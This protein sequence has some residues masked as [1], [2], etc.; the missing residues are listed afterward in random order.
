MK[1]QGAR[2]FVGRE[3]WARGGLLG[4]EA[5]KMA[6]A[7]ARGRRER[8][9]LGAVVRALVVAVS[10][11]ACLCGVFASGDAVEALSLSGF[12]SARKSAVGVTSPV[13]GSGSA[14]EVSKALG[15]VIP[16]LVLWEGSSSIGALGGALEQMGVLLGKVGAEEK[17]AGASAVAKARADLKGVDLRAVGAREAASLARGLLAAGAQLD[18]AKAGVPEEKLREL[19]GVLVRASRGAAASPEFAGHVLSGLDALVA[20]GYNQAISTVSVGAGGALEVAVTDLTGKPLRGLGVKVSAAKRL[21]GSGALGESDLSLS[22]V[23]GA[24]GVY[25][26]SVSSE[27]GQVAAVK[28]ALSELPEGIRA[29]PSEVGTVVIPASGGQNAAPVLEAATLTLSDRKSVVGEETATF[30]GTTAAALDAQAGNLV[31]V[32]VKGKRLT[33]LQHAAF[34]FE[35]V[36]SKKQLG[37]TAKPSSDTGLSVSISLDSTEF[38]SGTWNVRLVAGNTFAGKGAS[39]SWDLG[40]V[41]L[42]YLDVSTTAAVTSAAHVMPEIRW[43][44]EVPGSR[45]P[46]AVSLLFTALAVMPLAVVLPALLFG[47]VGGVRFFPSG[48]LAPVRLYAFVFHSSLVAAMVVLGAYWVSVDL[49]TTL[50]ILGCIAP[51]SALS[52]YYL[53]SGLAGIREKSE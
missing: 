43:T 1:A 28:V 51:I 18:G 25:A 42:T 6:S 12:A 37:F 32:E 16:A 10:L 2:T 44:F 33:A 23:P 11:C 3:R 49:M 9:E 48:D 40:S 27:K 45:P 21:M 7:R 35:H 53:L 24:E 52:G 19:A 26:A 14:S 39:L 36:Q 46:A 34:V 38:K 15:E 17:K 31:V 50:S 8:R 22:E 4:G 29:G 30:P 5:G 41:S 13:V 47:A 20:L